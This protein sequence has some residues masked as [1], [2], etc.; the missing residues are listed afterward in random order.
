MVNA[1][2]RS[3]RLLSDVIVLTTF[4]ICV[5]ALVGVQLFSGKLRN[6]CVSTIHKNHSSSNSSAGKLTCIQCN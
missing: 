6:Q 3:M 1:L 2:L 5:F 4:F